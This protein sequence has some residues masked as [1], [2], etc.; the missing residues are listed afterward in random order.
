V[1]VIKCKGDVMKILLKDWYLVCTHGKERLLS[2]NIWGVVE[3]DSTGKN[4]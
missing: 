3:S 4:K 1:T 2:K